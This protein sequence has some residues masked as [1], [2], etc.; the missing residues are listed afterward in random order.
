ML[1]RIKCRDPG[2]AFEGV[3]T[4]HSSREALLR[5]LCEQARRLGLPIQV[6]VSGYG[7]WSITPTGRAR[8]GA[9]FLADR[10]PKPGQAKPP[11]PRRRA[12]TR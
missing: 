3:W 1:V 7:A 6:E 11:R 12:R 8:P 10:L 9:L 5:Y 2:I 4:R